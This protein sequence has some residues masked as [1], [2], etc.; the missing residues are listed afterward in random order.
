M[1]P[2]YSVVEPHP[3]VPK[4]GG[5]VGGGRGGA[6]NFKRYKAEEITDGQN[7]SGPASRITLSRPFRR[8]IPAG[9]GGAG[10]MFSETEEPIFQFDEELKSRQ[11]STP[12]YRIG[13][14]GAG[15]MVNEI[16]ANTLSRKDSTASEA[17]STTS[18]FSISSIF[19]G[20]LS[21]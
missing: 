21:R 18:R 17:E 20:P 13:R 6:G 2:N 19:R 1:S 5:Y 12:V 10:N 9:R 14:G 16:K 7:A 3:T 4:S 8:H 11:H 15:N